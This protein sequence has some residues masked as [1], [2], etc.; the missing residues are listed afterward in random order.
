MNAKLALT[1]SALV[2]SIALA[3]GS[4]AP[5]ATAQTIACASGYYSDKRGNCQPNNPL[6]NLQPCPSGLLSEPAYNGSGYRCVPIPK[7]YE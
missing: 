5:A 2:G 4:A 3:A 1:T 6:P 7:G